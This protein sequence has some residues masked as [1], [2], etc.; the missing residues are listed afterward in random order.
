MRGIDKMDYKNIFSAGI[1]NILTGSVIAGGLAALILAAPL[2]AEQPAE[3]LKEE[4]ATAS[5]QLIIDGKD[6]SI[7]TIPRFTDIFSLPRDSAG[8]S[9]EIFTAVRDSGPN[10]G[11]D[12]IIL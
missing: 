12:M 1:S 9:A 6:Y 10:A 5:G 3:P 8:I 7:Y 2:K 11:I 4:Q